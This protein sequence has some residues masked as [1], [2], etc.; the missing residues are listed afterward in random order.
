MAVKITVKAVIEILG[1]PKEHVEETMKKIVEKLKQEYK[2]KEAK[3][4]EATEVKAKTTVLWN[5]F[6]DLE[7]IFED[8]Q[9]ITDFCFDYMPS[10][11]EIV[12]P[13]EL[14]IDARNHTDLINDLLARLHQYDMV[15]KNLNAENKLLKQQIISSNSRHNP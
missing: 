5:S 2:I 1:T 8:L 4:Y 14:K 15:V 13:L 11:I 6:V 7:M 3:V 12:E 10:S 9:K